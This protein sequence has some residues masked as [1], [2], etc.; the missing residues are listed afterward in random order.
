MK[1]RCVMSEINGCNNMKNLI[2]GFCYFVASMFCCDVFAATSE[3]QASYLWK[4]GIRAD[5]SH[6][7]SMF[8]GGTDNIC[9]GESQAKCRPQSVINPRWGD[10]WGILMMIAAD[11][12]EGG[13]QFCPMMVVGSQTNRSEKAWTTYHQLN[14]SCVWLCRAGYT[15]ERCTQR[16]TDTITSCNTAKLLQSNYRTLTHIN[17]DSVENIEWKIPNIW[18]DWYKR[19][20][21]GGFWDEHDM[22]FTIAEYLPSG[23]GAFVRPYVLQAKSNWVE[24]WTGGGGD[25][26][27]Y[28]VAYPAAN[29]VRKLGCL[30]GFKPNANGTDCEPIDVSACGDL[31]CDGWKSTNFKEDK[32][33]RTVVGNCLQW[34]CLEPGYTVK[35]AGSSECV[36][37][38][39]TQQDGANPTN[40]TCVHCPNGQYFNAEET[41]Y[42]FDPKK[43][44]KV[45]DKNTLLYGA[46]SKNSDIKQQC[47][48]MTGVTEYKTCVMKGAKQ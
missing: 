11:T 5:A 24:Q 4:W 45:L 37:C 48:V 1:I 27:S 20:G 21:Y 41:G 16:D 44:A 29:S 38:G 46:G 13:A 28:I 8:A 18:S 22:I 19:C 43:G 3:L 47:W 39:T 15:G 35:T 9:I 36:K 34:R 17:P 2:K 25:D 23:R 40:G 33:A 32:H 10:E 30:N 31:W 7:Q 26:G 42:C 12:S 6:C 14:G